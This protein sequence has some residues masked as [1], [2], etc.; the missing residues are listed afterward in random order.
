MSFPVPVERSRF[1]VM[2]IC[3]ITSWITVPSSAFIS[4]SMLAIVTR[5]SCWICCIEMICSMCTPIAIERDG[6]R[7]SVL[8]KVYCDAFRYITMLSSLTRSGSSN[9]IRIPCVQM[10][11]SP[12]VPVAIEWTCSCAFCV[13]MWKIERSGPPDTHAPLSELRTLTLGPPI[14]GFESSVCCVIYCYPTSYRARST[15]GM[16]SFPKGQGTLFTGIYIYI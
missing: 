11:N 14:T 2:V 9:F 3:P 1:P 7:H 15:L 4:V 13:G 16:H 6:K 5:H 8:K 12:A 10:I